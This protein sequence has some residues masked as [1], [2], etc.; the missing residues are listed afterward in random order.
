MRREGRLI[1]HEPLFQGGGK[2]RQW[3]LRRFWRAHILAPQPGE[4]S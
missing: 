3:L 2:R 4:R 1:D